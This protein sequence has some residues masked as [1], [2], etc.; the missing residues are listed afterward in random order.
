MSLFTSLC[1]CAYACAGCVFASGGV[2]G[3]ALFHYLLCRFGGAG[4]GYMVYA[5]VGARGYGRFGFGGVGQ[6]WIYAHLRSQSQRSRHVLELEAQIRVEPL[7]QLILSFGQ[8]SDPAVAKQDGS[9]PPGYAAKFHRH[10]F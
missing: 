5:R 8:L 7:I 3:H 10:S 1:L 2:C 9:V 6:I 4:V